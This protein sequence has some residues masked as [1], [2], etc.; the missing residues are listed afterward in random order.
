MLGHA[1]QYYRAPG[2]LWA[3]RTDIR[4]ELASSRTILNWVCIQWLC[5]TR[6]TR[7]PIR[8][9]N[10]LRNEVYRS[11]TTQ[12]AYDGAFGALFETLEFLAASSR[13]IPDRHGRSPTV[14]P[15]RWRL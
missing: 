2:V 15:V 8:F 7:L 9:Y 13:A 10:T 12:S 1:D 14:A 11:V 6:L 4:S 3:D 5:V